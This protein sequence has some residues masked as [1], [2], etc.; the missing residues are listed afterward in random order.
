[1]S[2]IVALMNGLLGAIC[3]VRFKVQIFVP[4]IAIG[5]VEVVL[6]RQ[7]GMGWSVLW[8]AIILIC[9]LEMGYLVGSAVSTLFAG[10]RPPKITLPF[11]ARE[12]RGL[13][14]H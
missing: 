6:L 8:S 10:L 14:H 13:S 3:G 9:S 11:H 12:H 1:M 2:L 4:L 5:L 7:V